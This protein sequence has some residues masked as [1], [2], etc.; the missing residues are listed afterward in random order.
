MNKK[1]RPNGHA[2]LNPNKYYQWE[3]DNSKA[4]TNK[5]CPLNTPSNSHNFTLDN[6]HEYHD[7]LLTVDPNNEDT[8]NQARTEGFWSQKGLLANPLLTPDTIHKLA[9]TPSLWSFQTHEPNQHA[10]ATAWILVSILEDPRTSNDLRAAIAGLPSNITLP[11][12]GNP[13]PALNANDYTPT[14]RAEALRRRIKFHTVMAGRLA[15]LRNLNLPTHNYQQLAALNNSAINEKLAKN[16]DVPET[17]RAFAALTIN[18]PPYQLYQ[19]L[20]Y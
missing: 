6:W 8:L 17:I 14:V 12:T 3:P 16:P 18:T 7:T 4:C 19:G 15:Q 11:E 2:S 9:L 10:E 1:H 20:D 5:E 13:H